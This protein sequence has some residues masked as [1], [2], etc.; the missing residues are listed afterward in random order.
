MPGFNIL[1]QGNAGHI[2][3]SR[4]IHINGLAIPVAPTHTLTRAD[5]HDFG[6]FSFSV[7]SNSVNFTLLLLLSGIYQ[8]L[9]KYLRI[10]SFVTVC[11][12]TEKGNR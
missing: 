8:C 2:Y 4:P 7:K 11:I 6:D 10:G 12:E 3:V 5:V 9:Y 1:G